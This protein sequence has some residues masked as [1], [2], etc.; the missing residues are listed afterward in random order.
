MIPCEDILPLGPTTTEALDTSTTGPVYPRI[1]DWPS[2]PFDCAVPIQ[3]RWTAFKAV[4]SSKKN[5]L[6]TYNATVSLL[7]LYHHLIHD[8]Y[9][10]KRN[11]TMFNECMAHLSDNSGQSREEQRHEPLAAD[12]CLHSIWDLRLV[13]WV[14]N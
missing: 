11:I 5:K 13:Q 9:K 2:V 1:S 4:L 14:C 7:P 10:S 8:T 6:V 12:T 3:H